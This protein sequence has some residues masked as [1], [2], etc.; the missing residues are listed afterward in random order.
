VPLFGAAPRR[1]LLRQTR[2]R[3]GQ[4]ETTIFSTDNSIY[5]LLIVRYK[6]AFKTGIGNIS[7]MAHASPAHKV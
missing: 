7:K 1:C 2:T 5:R 3:R 6:P 4:H